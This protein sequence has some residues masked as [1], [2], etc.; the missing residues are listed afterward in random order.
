MFY[1]NCYELL[2]N[3]FWEFKIIG[4]LISFYKTIGCVELE[5]YGYV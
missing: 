2:D 1:G 5:T 4:L 3:S